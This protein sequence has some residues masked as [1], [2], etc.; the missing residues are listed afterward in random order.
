M[1]EYNADQVWTENP[2]TWDRWVGYNY[3]ADRLNRSSVNDNGSITN[4]AVSAL[5]QYVSTN[6]ETIYHDANFNVSMHGG[7]FYY[8]DA[9]NRLTS[10]RDWTGT[11]LLQNTYD[12]LG[13]CVKRDRH[14]WGTFVE[15]ITYDGWKPLI[16]WNGAGNWQAWNVYGPGADEILWRR[17]IGVGDLRYHHDSHGNVTALLDWSGNVL[18]KYTYD[19]FG[20]P[21][22]TDG[23]DTGSKYPRTWSSYGNR[24]MFTGREY[25]PG[26]WLYDYRHRWYDAQLGRFLQTDPLGLQTE[27]EKLSAAQKALFFGG[28]AP[29]TFSTSEMNLYRYCGDDPVDRS[30]PLGLAPGDSYPTLDAAA[31]QAIR[32]INETSIALGREYSGMLYRMRD[33]SFSYTA[34]TPGTSDTSPIGRRVPAKT[35]F[36]GL[37]HTHG[38]YDAEHDYHNFIFSTRDR[39]NADDWNCPSYLGNPA[40]EVRKYTPN[41]IPQGGRSETIATSYPL[42]PPPPSQDRTFQD[43]FVPFSKFWK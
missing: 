9:Q 40:R 27:G 22:I 12:G 42:P 30:D 16:E 33:G 7:W 31:I 3:T 6:G 20:Q 18:E 1:A 14:D 43:L 4:Y 25:F 2:S 41:L 32:D 17:Q 38:K 13:R 23:W 15:L 11:V 24:F 21:R 28:S 36:A 26:L 39:K 37:Y 8:Y 19:V 29:E 35:T 10:V 34:P 5:N